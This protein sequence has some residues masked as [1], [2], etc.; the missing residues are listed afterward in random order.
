MPLEVTH[1]ARLVRAHQRAITGDICGQDGSEPARLAF[2]HGSSPGPSVAP[3][4]GVGTTLHRTAKNTTPQRRDAGY[5][6]VVRGG[7]PAR[8]SCANVFYGSCGLRSR[9]AA[10]LRFSRALTRKSSRRPP[11]PAATRDWCC[12]RSAANIRANDP[13]HPLNKIAELPLTAFELPKWLV[14][15]A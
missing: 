10:P 4:D 5:W 8:Y 9:E 2:T 14:E 13:R 1:G 3:V 15:P 7:F 11:W 12:A 6:N